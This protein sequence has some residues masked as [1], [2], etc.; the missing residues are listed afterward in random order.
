MGN[1]HL[2]YERYLWFEAEIKKNRYPNA[3]TLAE[4]FEISERTAR[5]GRFLHLAHLGAGHWSRSRALTPAA[6]GTP[7]KSA[8]SAAW[9]R[10]FVTGVSQ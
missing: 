4:Q 7:G 8:G 5:R 6:Q 2:I 10:S 9:Q 3:R 1:Q